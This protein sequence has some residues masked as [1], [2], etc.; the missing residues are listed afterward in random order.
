MK[1]AEKHLDLL[2]GEFV[3]SPGPASCCF[4][5]SFE[6]L[7]LKEENFRWQCFVSHL[8][9]ALQFTKTLA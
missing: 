4:L 9:G 1:K 2:L 5:L 8:S 7:C 3:P 6:A